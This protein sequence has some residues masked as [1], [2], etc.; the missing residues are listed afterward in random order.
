M[1]IEYVIATVNTNR[2]FCGFEKKGGEPK[3]RHVNFP[4]E[5]EVYEE[6]LAAEKEIERILDRYTG[7]EELRLKIEKHYVKEPKY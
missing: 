5:R 3:L 6:C 1:K 4:Y 7:E 2:Y